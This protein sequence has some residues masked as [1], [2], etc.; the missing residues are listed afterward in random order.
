MRGWRR[1]RGVNNVWR[2][3]CNGFGNLDREALHADF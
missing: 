2:A 1:E 3:V